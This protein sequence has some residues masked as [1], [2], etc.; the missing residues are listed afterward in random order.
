MDGY[1][2]INYCQSVTRGKQR[3]DMSR[4][5]LISKDLRIASLYVFYF[6]LFSHVFMYVAVFSLFIVSCRDIIDA[7]PSQ[8]ALFSK[9]SILFPGSVPLARYN[10]L[11]TSCQALHQS[12]KSLEIHRSYLIATSFPS[13]SFLF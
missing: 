10:H 7:L 1:V 5:D 6:I 13:C 11:S 4:H 8:I 2:T 3:N 12:L 9:Q